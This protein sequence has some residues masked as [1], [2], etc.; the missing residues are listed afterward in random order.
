M[1]DLIDILRQHGY[2]DSEEAAIRLGVSSARVRGLYT[3]GRLVGKLLAKKL[4]VTVESVDDY[5]HERL[6]RGRP[7][8]RGI[9]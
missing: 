2:I 4:F 8:T 9:N 7:K 1:N 6:P 3:E 5:S